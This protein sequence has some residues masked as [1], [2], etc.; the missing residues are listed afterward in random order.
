MNWDCQLGLYFV[1]WDCQLGLSTVK[2]ICQVGRLS[3]VVPQ[4]WAC[5]T[6]VDLE[7]VMF[8]NTAELGGQGFQ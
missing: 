1:N 5:G 3:A 8:E 7:S 6:L 4:L 2:V